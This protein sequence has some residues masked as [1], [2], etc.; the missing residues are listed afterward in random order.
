MV[1]YNSSDFINISE[2]GFAWRITNAH[3]DNCPQEVLDRIHPLS[4]K[5]SEEVYQ[6]TSPFRYPLKLSGF[7]EVSEVSLEGD[8]PQDNERINNWLI[9]LPIKGTESIYV[10]WQSDSLIAVTPAGKQQPWHNFGSARSG[11]VVTCTFLL[12]NNGAHPL[13][14]ERIQSPCGCLAVPTFPRA[15]PGVRPCFPTPPSPCAFVSTPPCSGCC[16]YFS[17]FSLFPSFSG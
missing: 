2:F 1:K 8:S 16:P 10:C 15:D 13:Q 14:I 7:M 6:L 3:R 4:A 17:L 9:N 12:K 5:C 11:Q